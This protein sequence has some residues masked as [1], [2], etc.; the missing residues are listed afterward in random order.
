MRRVK[1]MNL[2]NFG[3][4]GQSRIDNIVNAFWLKWDKKHGTVRGHKKNE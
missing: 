2:T 4:E 3:F 1:N